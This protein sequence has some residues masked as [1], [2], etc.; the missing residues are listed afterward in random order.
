MVLILDIKVMILD[1]K[2]LILDIKSNSMISTRK[3]HVSNCV[4]LVQCDSWGGGGSSETSSQPSLDFPSRL[5]RLGRA[6]RPLRNPPLISY[7]RGTNVGLSLV[8]VLLIEPFFAFF[9][10]VASVYNGGFPKGH[11][12]G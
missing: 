2:V 10:G 11:Y 7:G 3:T 12:Q 8:E 1:I 9:G 5:S 6:L 4:P